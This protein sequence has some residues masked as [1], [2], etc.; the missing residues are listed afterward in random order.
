MT[1]HPTGFVTFLFTD[2]EGSTMLAQ[3]HDDVL[4]HLLSRHKEIIKNAVES[5]SGVVFR[6]A[7]DSACCAFSNG[8]DAVNAATDAQSRLLSEDWKAAEIRVRMGIHSG[9]AQYNG[10]D[11][12]GYITLA[13]SNRVMSTAYGG[14]II[15]SERVYED[16]KGALDDFLTRGITFRDLGERRLKD[17][18]NPIRLYQVIAPG[19]REDFP[20]LKTLDARPNN[21]PVQLTSFVGREEVIKQLKERLQH[22]HLLTLTGFGGTGKTRIALQLAADVIDEFADGVFHSE[23]SPLNDPSLIPQAIQNALGLQ[24]EPGS[25]VVAGIIR[26]LKDKQML[27]ILD[28]CEHMIAESARICEQLLSNCPQLR[29]I[30]TSREKLQCI[31]EQVFSIPR[32]EIPDDTAG[33]SPAQLMETESVKLFAERAVAVN[34]DFSITKDNSASVTE[35]CRQ[36]EGIPLALE[37]AA[38]KTAQLT[39]A[40]ISERLSDRFRLLSGGRRTALAKEQ[41]LG[42]MVGWSYDML[43]GSEK[44]LLNNLSVFSGGWTLDAAEVVCSFDGMGDDSMFEMLGSLIDKS[45]IT[46]DLSVSRYSMLETIREYAALKLKESDLQASLE[47]R[48]IDFFLKLAEE[49]AVAID[50]MPEKHRLD[51]LEAEM[52][53]FRKAMKNSLKQERRE[54]GVRI[55]INLGRFFE[56]RGYIAEGRNHITELLG[57]PDM[58]SSKHR[59][60]AFQWLGTFG[61]ISGDLENAGLYYNKSLRLYRSLGNARGVS[62][63]L[64]NLALIAQTRGQYEKAKLLNEKCLKS[65]MKIGEKGLIADTLLNSVAPFFHLREY[66][67]AKENL[68]MS[69]E[70]YRGLNDMRGVSLALTNLGS[71]AGINHEFEDSVKYLHE[72]M[73]IQRELGDTRGLAFT[74]ESLG[75][76]SGNLGK[77]REAA[78]YFEESIR[79]NKELGDKKNLASVLSNYGFFKHTIGNDEE[80]LSLHR[81]CLELSLEIGYEAGVNNSLAGIAEALCGSDTETSGRITGFIEATSAP[82]LHPEVREVFERTGLRLMELLGEKHGLILEE[83]SRMSL[84]EIVKMLK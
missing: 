71:I 18:I 36:L 10:A 66:E 23:L 35:L 26:H 4:P 80:S 75:T 49:S 56:I 51:R 2:I 32:L 15:I 58:I 33:L 28:N 60:R 21:L 53:N 42:A 27:L 72:S 73:V 55:A 13:R 68:K 29:I 40:Q 17:V 3:K 20:P 54:D 6:M 34:P 25:S 61:W 38:V 65:V 46:F 43:T 74:L 57:D 44:A 30:A 64:G 50:K 77:N 78:E 83:G 37:L 52:N 19:L 59:A 62:T 8:R 45:L 39:P 24:D 47:S 11:Y 14:Q 22:T 84:E 70:I 12:T 81:K 41:T 1:D 7:G 9:E 63:T 31:G 48:H 67:K 69:L 79:I 5:N 16:I 82:G 76:I